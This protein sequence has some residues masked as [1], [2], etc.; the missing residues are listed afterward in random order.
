MRDGQA[1]VLNA[2]Q[3]DV[4][5]KVSLAGKLG[6]R[7]F[8]MLVLS[9][10]LGLRVGEI[11]KLNVSDVVDDKYKLRESFALKRKNTK[12]KRSREV[13][14]TSKRVID[15]LTAW[16]AHLRL[17]GDPAMDMTLFKSMKGN[18]MSPNALQQLFARLYKVAG[19]TGCK[20]HSGRR[21]FGTNLI[22]NGADLKSVKTL[23]GHASITQTAKYVDT[24]PDLLAKVAEKAMS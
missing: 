13:Y 24:M 11:A 22:R 6:L 17:K 23:M 4:V 19:F 3:R 18:R 14:V 8:T 12:R 16:I 5:M 2:A 21:T 7:D 1:R 10:G 9:F 15:A 20:S